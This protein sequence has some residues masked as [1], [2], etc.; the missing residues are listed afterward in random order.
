MTIGSLCGGFFSL[1]VISMNVKYIVLFGILGGLSGAY[2]NLMTKHF[3]KR[4][5]QKAKKLGK[6]KGRKPT[7]RILSDEVI[8]LA[9]QGNTKKAI[10]E[11]LNIGTASVFRI[12]KEYKAQSYGPCHQG[13]L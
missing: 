7:A 1:Q 11:K 9:N 5:I 2:Y 12:L 13:P 10:A 4:K 6:Y 3:I 8:S